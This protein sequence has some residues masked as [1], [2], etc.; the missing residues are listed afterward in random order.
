MLLNQAR[1]QADWLLWNEFAR[2]HNSIFLIT[3]L[4]VLALPKNIER[5]KKNH[6]RVSSCSTHLSRLQN[7]KNWRFGDLHYLSPR[8]PSGGHHPRCRFRVFPNEDS[9]NA[10][11]KEMVDIASMKEKLTGCQ[12]RKPKKSGFS[13][14]VCH[15]QLTKFFTTYFCL[16]NT[17]VEN[18]SKSLFLQRC[19]RSELCFFNLTKRLYF[20]YRS[21][22]DM[23]HFTY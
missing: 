19:E 9:K 12:Q 20:N 22:M 1:Y 18:H 11:T 8:S 17:V 16:Q 2:F 15:C 5:N 10:L 23:R 6:V 14:S 21:K 4:S 3:K 7:S 13:L